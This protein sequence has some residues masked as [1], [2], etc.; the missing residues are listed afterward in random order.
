AQDKSQDVAGMLKRAVVELE[1][2]AKDN[3]IAADFAR[4]KAAVDRT[5]QQN[6]DALRETFMEISDA[7]IAIGKTARLPADAPATSVF[8]CPMKKANWL[9]PPGGTLNPY[10]GSTMLDC[11]AAVEALPRTENAPGATT[12]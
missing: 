12:R 8:R 3:R 6:L 7:M 2:L 4:L 11:G 10:Y 5:P 1:P 9:Q